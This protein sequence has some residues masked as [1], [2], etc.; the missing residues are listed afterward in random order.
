M[1][2]VQIHSKIG[3]FDFMMND[4]LVFTG[5]NHQTKETIYKLI[6][7]NFQST[8]YSVIEE[9]TLGEEGIKLLINDKV[10]TSRKLKYISI[11]SIND[12]MNQ[13]NIEKKNLL[14]QIMISILS[15]F[16]FSEIFEE[17]GDLLLKVESKLNY[18]L[19]EILPNIELEFDT[20]NSEILYRKFSKLIWTKNEH[21]QLDYFLD[22]EIL[23]DNFCSLLETYIEQTGEHVCIQIKYPDVFLSEKNMELFMRRLI[24]INKKYKKIF[25]FIYHYQ[26]CVD[27]GIEN[28]TSIVLCTNI[29]QQLPEFEFYRNSIERYYPI[30]LKIGDGELYSRTINILPYTGNKLDYKN[31]I[32]SRDMVL[33]KLLNQLLDLDVYEETSSAG[34]TKYEQLY[35][36]S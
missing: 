15:D 30:E 19:R 7:R 21:E 20:F 1:E 36:L 11:E 26:K 4:C 29:I 12:L 6:N 5:C 22:H 10:I 27:F 23:I 14:D 25:L 2:R 32:S 24:D 16:D 8:T 17:L 13:F 31:L 18:K 28:F 9:D 33:L 3:N 35:L 34:L